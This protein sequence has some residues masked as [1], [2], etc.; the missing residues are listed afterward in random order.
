MCPQ[1]QKTLPHL[2]KFIRRSEVQHVKRIHYSLTLSTRGPSVLLTSQRD[3][4]QNYY[5]TT[6]LPHTGLPTVCY[7]SCSLHE[8]RNSKHHATQLRVNLFPWHNSPSVGVDLLIIEASRSSSL[9]TT[10]SVGLLWT[11]DQSDPEIS[12]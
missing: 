9:G 6:T 8:K 2:G 5:C 11:S 1:K 10:Q 7:M 12:T 4:L 3:V